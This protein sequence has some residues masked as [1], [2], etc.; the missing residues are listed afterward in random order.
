MNSKK[1]IENRLQEVNRLIAEMD[2][3]K[4][5]R[6]YQIGDIMNIKFRD[7]AMSLRKVG[8]NIYEVVSKGDSIKVKDGDLLRIQDENAI[9][10]PGEKIV[11]EI[12][13]KAM[14]YQSDPI[15]QVQ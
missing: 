7:V 9:L 1:N 3:S 15:E 8:Y 5:V 14:D 13:R 2:G 12:F 11:F 4:S 6:D 10:Q